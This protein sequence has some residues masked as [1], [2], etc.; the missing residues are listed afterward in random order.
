MN[1]QQLL[2]KRSLFLMKKSKGLL[3][4]LLLA[5]LGGTY[6]DLFFVGAGLYTFPTRP[7][8]SIFSIN[9]TFT[10]IGLPI[11]T[12]IFL[13]VSSN[14]RFVIK[15]AIILFTS[16]LMTVLE[17]LGED[18]GYFAHDPSWHHLYSFFGYTLFLALVSLFH[19]WYREKQN[20]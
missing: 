1:W 4:V 7:F 20:K 5:S 11:V 18:F 12:G 15:A 3:P 19:S 16:L 10:L 9:I 13:F 2:R 6:L 14:K 17:K 8:M